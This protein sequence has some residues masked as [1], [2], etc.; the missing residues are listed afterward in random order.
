MY[1]FKHTKSKLLKIIII[2]VTRQRY[3]IKKYKQ[4]RY[5]L[6]KILLFKMDVKESS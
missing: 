2:N 5:L 3:T 1:F 6:N 4:T